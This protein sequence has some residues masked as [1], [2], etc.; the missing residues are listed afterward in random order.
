MI[1]LYYI[2]DNNSAGPF[3]TAVVLAK[4]MSDL[5]EHTRNNVDVILRKSQQ[6]HCV[7]SMHRFTMYAVYTHVVEYSP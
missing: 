2:V 6:V 1:L 3:R 5:I 4:S 7:H